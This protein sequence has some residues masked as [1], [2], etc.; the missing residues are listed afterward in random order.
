LTTTKFHDSGATTTTFRDGVDVPVIPLPPKITERDWVRIVMMANHLALP[1]KPL[2]SRCMTY[3]EKMVLKTKMG[4]SDF[5]RRCPTATQ[6]VG[7]LCELVSPDPDE[8]LVDIEAFG[9]R[10]LWLLQRVIAQE[11]RR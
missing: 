7:A 4:H 11:L 10:A 9:D 6:M 3:Q 1:S 5:G 8:T 2:E